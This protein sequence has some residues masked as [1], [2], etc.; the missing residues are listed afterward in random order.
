VTVPLATAVVCTITNDDIA[1]S[2]QIVKRVV[3]NNG[4]TADY[5]AFGLASTAG[6][7]TFGSGTADGANTL[8]YSS[9]VISV[10]AG[11][12]TLRENDIAGYGE[13]TWTCTGAAA[14][15]NTISAGAVTVP[16][17]TA[18]VC[19]I[20]NDDIAGSL[21][22]VKRVVNNNG[23]TADYSAFGL[24]STAGSLTF[25]AGTA[26][27]AN[28]LKYSSQVITVN[29][30]SYTLRE[31]DIA[32]YTEGTWTCTGAAASN[33]TISA[34]AVT[35]PL[36]TAVVCTITNDDQPATLIVKKVVIGDGAT[37]GFTGTGSGVDA[38]FSLAPASNSFTTVSF[39]N[40]N[41]GTKTVTETLLAGYVLTDLGCT[42][43][44]NV[45]SDGVIYNPANTQTVSTTLVNGGTVT[46]TFVNEQQVGQTTRTQGFWATHKTLANVAWFG[47]DYAGNHFAGVAQSL[48]DIALCGRSIDTIDK[49]M[50]GFWSGISFTSTKGKR[51]SL[52]QAR[53]RLLQQLLAA[54]LNHSA[55]G[56]S[57]SGTTFAAA[58]AA[59]CGTDVTAINNAASAMGAFNESGDSGLF[60]PGVSANA[61]EAKTTALLSFWDVLP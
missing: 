49:L 24:A 43:N 2:L 53:M 52:D 18:V 58:E 55:F 1:G 13:G 17:A 40:I 47:G 39:S 35:V 59:Y 9:Q 14:S 29:A 23:G 30:G 15:N 27:G 20:T 57:P 54:E 33:S 21:Q 51:S 37:F 16:L 26:D 61:K 34:G 28:T 8:K 60:T 42:D 41:A 38:T 11:S 45:N 10:S 31:N 7:L 32:G 19:T 5:S 12:Y 48:G 4:G 3:N 25:G 36:E 44:G 6:S 22:I 46:C 50:G 56:S